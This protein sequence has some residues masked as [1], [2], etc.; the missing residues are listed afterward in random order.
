MSDIF[1]IS[2]QESNAEK[3]WKRLLE[4]HPDAKR[5]HGINGIDRIHLACESLSTSKNFWTVDGDNWLLKP[6]VYNQQITHDLILFTAQDPIQNTTSTLGAVKLWTV[7]KIVA[8]DM[9]HGEFSLNAT[10]SKVIV[11]NT[12]SIT[13]Y[14][15]TPFDAWRAAFRHCVKLTSVIFKNRPGKH[16]R[17]QFVN[18]WIACKDLDDGKN[19]AAWC[20]RGYQDAVA[21]V[22][23]CQDDML[24]LNLINNY[25]WLQEHFNK[26]RS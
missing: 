1:F 17:E 18:S 5:I 4:L 2:Y 16:H 19:N 15:E 11:N 20:Y 3:N 24:R 22:N 13:A 7:D 8:K 14:N 26:C 12:F 6:L 10:D 21:Y 25:S 23:E 9:R